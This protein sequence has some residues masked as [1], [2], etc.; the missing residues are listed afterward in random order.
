MSPG[1]WQIVIVILLAVLLFGGGGKISSMMGD[2]AKG[3]KAFRKGLSDDD[4]KKVEDRS[5]EA[6]DAAP[7]KKSE[8][9]NPAKSS[10]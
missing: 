8:A 1:V 10:E 5:G 4:S 2:F 7:A 6:A 9:A 3:I